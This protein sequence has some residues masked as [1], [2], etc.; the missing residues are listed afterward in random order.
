MV[1]TSTVLRDLLRNAPAEN[2]TFGWL[3]HALGERSFGIALLLLGLLACL[4]GAS[5]IAGAVIAFPAYQMLLARPEPIFP[6]YVAARSFRTQ[7]IATI[8]KR[9]VPPLQYLERFI[10]PRWQTPFEMT[11]R[12]VGG[13]ILLLGILLLAPIPLSNVPPG[14]VVILLSIAYIEEDG[15]LLC[16]ALSLAVIL[17]L[18]AA[19]A[20]W[21]VANTA[22]WL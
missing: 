20:I 22:R 6:R 5:A 2:V 13:T 9:I 16:I 1:A 21:H 8:L 7:R 12:V 11:K 17:F 14:L 19:A 3:I 18:I 4:P 10:R 15:V